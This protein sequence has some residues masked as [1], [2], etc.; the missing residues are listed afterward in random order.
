MNLPIKF[1]KDEDV[2]AEEVR[3]FRAL[4]PEGQVRELDEMFDVYHFLR[5][6]SGRPEVIDRMAADD[7]RSEREAILEFAHRHV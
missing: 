2:I 6:A 1:P 3:R 7:E 4:S 5:T